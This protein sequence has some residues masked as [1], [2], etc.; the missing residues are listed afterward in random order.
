M[1]DSDTYSIVKNEG[2]KVNSDTALAK[3]VR[4]LRGSVSIL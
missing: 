4:V 2:E 1:F 3:Q